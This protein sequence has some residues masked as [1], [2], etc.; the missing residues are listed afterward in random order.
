MERFEVLGVPV[1]G[2]NY[3]EALEALKTDIAVEKH[4]FSVFLEA[5]LLYSLRSINGLEKTLGRAGYIF[6]DGTAVVK[7]VKLRYGK[8]IERMPGPTFILKACDF[9][10]R[11]NWRHYFYG[12]APGTAEKLAGKL[13]E[14]YPGLEVAGV[15]SPPFRR[16]SDGKIEI[17]P[18]EDAAEI[19]M[20]NDVKPDIVWVGLGGPKQEYWMDAH[21][22]KI[23][24]PL[25]MGVGA[26]FDF[27]S[28]N[29]PWAP[30]WIRQIGMEWL[31]RMCSGGRATFKR[32]LKC[33]ASSAGLLIGYFVKYKLLRRHQ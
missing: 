30:D 5:N 4:S 31:F 3:E 11:F 7:A 33:V 22:N 21:L 15:F 9:G 29:R 19:K 20:I 32:N 10:R 17:A 1:C 13:R 28:G 26:A 8:T 16:V 25:M 23:A 6:P 24:A 27:H 18:D 14:L 2:S 12:G